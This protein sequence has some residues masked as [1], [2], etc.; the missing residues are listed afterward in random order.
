[1]NETFQPKNHSVLITGCSSGIGRA[2]AIHLAERGFTV[3]AT[4]RKDVDADSLR[5]L[6]LPNLIPVC[7]LDLRSHGDISRAAGLVREELARR[8]QAGLYALINNAG[9]GFI[10]P[11][12]LMDL[13]G[14]QAELE[15]RLLGPVALA[16]AFLPLIREAGGRLLWVVTPGLFPTPYVASI[17]ACDFAANCLARTLALELKPWKTPSILIRCGGIQ[18]PSV[19]RSS[20][21]LDESLQRWPAERA[22]LY[23]PALRRL[24]AGLEDFDRKRTPPEAVA[25]TIYTALAARS[26]RPRY[27]VGYLSGAGAFLE[28]LPQ[29]LTDAILA[30]RE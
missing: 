29:T 10:A 14:F 13:D 7:P 27:R 1:M 24:R 22:A 3:F 2:A 5:A 30:R 19:P 20:A 9:G 23:A 17:H 6:A 26:P 11:I 28:A 16:Q 18:T 21:G 12:E 4:V 25:R 8:G 15:T